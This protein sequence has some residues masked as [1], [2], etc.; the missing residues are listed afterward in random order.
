MQFAETMFNS[1]EP[2]YRSLAS[3]TRLHP[4]N[5]ALIRN[6]CTLSSITTELLLD[7]DLRLSH[8][9][10]DQIDPTVRLIE[11]CKELG[12]NSYITGP[13]GLDYL[14]LDYF[15]KANIRVEV[16]NYAR[17]PQYRQKFPGYVPS[18]SVL[19]FIS[20]VGP[21]DAAAFFRSIDIA[22]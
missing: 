17:L 5:M 8:P 12:A 18:V 19:D 10:L 11:I 14:N 7:S 2:V 20:A 1:I 22:G 9:S 6:I 15:R 13:R 21:E 16:A 4:I 3:E